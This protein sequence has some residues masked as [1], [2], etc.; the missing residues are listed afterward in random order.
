MHLMNEEEKKIE[1]YK[2]LT[3]AEQ[4][5]FLIESVTKN[6][7]SK[8]FREKKDDAILGSL[9]ADLELAKKIQVKKDE[10]IDITV[11]ESKLEYV[12]EFL[13]DLAHIGN[14]KKM[15]DII[16]ELRPKVKHLEKALRKELVS[17]GLL[18]EERHAMPF[19]KSILYSEDDVLLRRN[20]LTMKLALRG[21]S[22]PTKKMLFIMAILKAIN[23]LPNYFATNE[24]YEEAEKRLKELIE[25]NDDVKELY[26]A[27]K[28]QPEV[29]KHLELAQEQFVT[30]MR[31]LH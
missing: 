26:E 2:Q 1:E 16:Q 21:D 24:E 19:M 12:D 7:E 28:E 30:G 8:D 3:L 18:I 22:S 31:G 27:L 17:K 11:Q 15:K 20:N 6:N 29:Q 14:M 10:I 9:V 5:L 13:E 23:F 25:Q 4:V